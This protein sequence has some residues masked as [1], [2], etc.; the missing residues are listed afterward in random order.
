MLAS[1][2]S[3][4]TT[5]SVLALIIC[6]AIGVVGRM[7]LEHFPNLVPEFSSEFGWSRSSIAS[8]FSLCALTHG[9]TGPFAGWMFDRFGPV[10]V[11]STGFFF[12]GSGLIITGFGSEL[13][14]MYAGL[15]L[16][17]G[18]SAA[19]CGNVP[20]STLIS[21]WFDAKLPLA[22]SII[23]SAYGAG[24]F[25]G[26][27]AS[28]FLIT[29]LGW[30]DAEIYLGLGILATMCV[31]WLLPWKKLS[32]GLSKNTTSSSDHTL[33][34]T[35]DI[36][37]KEAIKTPAFWGLSGVFFFTANGTYG[38]LFQSVSYLIHRGLAP[39]EAS[40]NL[41]LTG[42]LVP[43]GMIFCGYLL[44]RF[45]IIVIG[46]STH[47]FTAIAIA[48]LWLFDGGENRF[49]LYAFIIFFGLTAGTRA[50]I[51]GSLASR[52]FKGRNFGVIYG[53]ISV[54]GGVGIAIGS[55]MSG[56]IFDI[57]QSYGAAFA[58]AGTC[59]LIGGL[60]ILLIP[61]LRKAGSQNRG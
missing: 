60:P 20:N 36:T 5:M 26:L 31:L 44:T 58:Y 34:Q 39:L 7:L 27:S 11:F 32:S 42:I 40:F 61:T 41:G 14:H 25:V 18:L 46:Y 56:F 45:N 1:R 38:T 47:I 28:Q 43:P 21:R 57:T 4:F 53:S 51:A 52:L 19:L 2:N 10:I 49:F 8:I 9:I 48:S 59:M 6:F 55:F 23:F 13:W 30:R 54:G 16:M 37:L 12:A 29:K 3:E 50:P 33:H 15:G 17:V 35:R 24:S 22:L